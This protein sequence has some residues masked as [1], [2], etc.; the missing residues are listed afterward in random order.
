LHAPRIC[1]SDL[2]CRRHRRHVHIAS[3]VDGTVT[4]TPAMETMASVVI[5]II[6][7]DIGEG[8][9]GEGLED[10]VEQENGWCGVKLGSQL[11]IGRK[12]R[13]AEIL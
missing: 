10:G 11:W 4:N 5:S 13:L 7:T 8:Y 3:A 12:H 6:V 1:L 9:R 2:D